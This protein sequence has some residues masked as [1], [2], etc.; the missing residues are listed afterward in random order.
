VQLRATT[1]L[2]VLCALAAPASGNPYETFISIDS[3]EDLY[4]LQATGQ[5]DDEAL[6]NLVELYQRGVD[7]N[8]A[9]REQLYE[10]PNLTYAEVDAILEY[11]QLTGW[12]TDPIDLVINNV[13]TQE[14]LEAIAAFLVVTDPSRSVLATD[15]WI[16]SQTRL[17]IEAGG[18]PPVALQARVGT[19][20]YLTVG[21]AG[22]MSRSRLDDIRYDPSRDALSA[23]EANTTVHVP[24]LYAKWETDR[25]GI[26]AGTYR[27]GFG[28]R[29]TFDNT[30][31]YT[32]NGFYLDDEIYRVTETT[33]ECKLSEGE[34]G[35]S[36]CG[37]LDVYSSPDYRWREG[38][39][40]VAAGVK[41]VPLG[42][43]RL[44][45]FG[46]ASY[47][48]RSIYQYE[49]YRPDMCADPDDDMNE[50]CSA[51]DVYRR[52]DDPF[53]P[54]ARFS[55]YTLPDM[56]A[57]TT[58]G[59]NV[60]FA[61]SRRSHVGVTGYGSNVDWLV[62]GMELDFQEWSRYP[63]GGPFGALG[64]DGAY[65]LGKLDF[66]A[67]LT[68][69]FDSMGKEGDGGYGGILRQVTTFEKYNELEASLRY[70]DQHF[71]NP[72]ARPIAAPDELEGVRARDEAGARLRYTAR[73]QKRFTLR[74]MTDVWQ[75]P[76]DGTEDFLVYARGDVDFTDQYTAGLWLLHQNKDIS[77]NGLGMDRCYESTVDE[78]ETGEP[79]PCTGEKY[80]AIGRLRYRPTRRYSLTAQYLHEFLTDGH[81][82]NKYR[83]DASGTLIGTARPTDDLRL[84][85]R[86]RYLI[87]D[88][89]DDMYL[90]E[91]VWAYLDASYRVRARDR[92][93]LRYDVY[94]YLDDREST[95]ARSPS[96]EHW[97]WLEYESRF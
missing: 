47:Q 61:L 81:Y 32:P 16:R 96:P 5:I 2:L 35:A 49:I 7:L 85:G 88:I 12:I 56:Y 90:E 84:R 53:E 52:L 13:L 76:S 38:L 87:E 54:T 67:E 28:Q 89:S 24:K 92:V 48:P 57:E 34:L 39:L 77:D 79:I 75:S 66:F 68:R 65:G 45:A 43:G 86:V 40:G 83:Q 91:S 42:A 33:L 4:D 8:R 93:R 18:A 63:F 72:Y 3:E 59:G 31:L 20:Q 23:V 73:L 51:P 70:Y 46:F 74:A 17:L 60:A 10:L 21:M 69:S 95:A 37:D 62:E 58:A 27:I 36:P 25:W 22:T 80:Q 78:D 15:G 30:S 97:L 19:F 82:D 71:K 14:K 94:V 41:A 29:L 50:A 55:Y 6:A 26:I 64:V 44:Q 1:S 11:R 9:S